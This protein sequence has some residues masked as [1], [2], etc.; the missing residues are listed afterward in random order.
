MTSTDSQM[1]LDDLFGI[2]ITVD[3]ASDFIQQV[4]TLA[5]ELHTIGQGIDEK[6]KSILDEQ[7][8]DNFLKYMEEHDMK[9]TDMKSIRQLLQKVQ[10]YVMDL[11]VMTVTLSF[12]PRQTLVVEIV[13]WLVDHGPGPLKLELETERA[14]VAGADI[15]W[16]GTVGRYSLFNALSDDYVASQL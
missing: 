12:R 3:E 11:P 15:S 1:N 6:M 14:L 10:S 7:Y 16:D 13:Q 5:Q 9:Q 2:V 4:R 8:L